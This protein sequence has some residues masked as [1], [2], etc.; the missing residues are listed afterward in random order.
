M[1]L[2]IL[3]SLLIGLI[4]SVTLGPMGFVI[5]QRALSKGFKSGLASALGFIFVDIIYALIA[6][7]SVSFLV[8]IIEDY[9]NEL[10]LF[11]G[12]IVVLIGIGLN[13]SNPIK[14]LRKKTTSKRDLLKDFVSVFFMTLPNPSA[15]I[16]FTAFFATF[17]LVQ[18]EHLFTDKLLMITFLFIGMLIAWFVFI[19]FLVKNRHRIGIRQLVLINNIISYVII[20]AGVGIL[21]HFTYVSLF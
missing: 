10:Q 18:N 13:R 16:T 12:I 19:Y 21:G 5:I 7:F 1:I 20:A 6:V 9:N 3:K 17:N 4:T 11:G 8:N 15:Y 14:N 2:V